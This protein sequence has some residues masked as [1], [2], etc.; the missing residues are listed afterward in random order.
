[1]RAIVRN[2]E[3]MTVFVVVVLIVVDAKFA[4]DAAELTFC[5]RVHPLV[6][7]LVV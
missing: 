4:D 1:V 7:L 2:S 3:I 5:P 6:Q